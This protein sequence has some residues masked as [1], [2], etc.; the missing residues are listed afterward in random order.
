M[1]SNVSTT[2]RRVT[3]AISHFGLMAMGAFFGF[4]IVSVLEDGI[5]LSLYAAHAFLAALALMAVLLIYN[6]GY[7]REI[8]RRE[9]EEQK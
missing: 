3:E 7:L 9:K 4:I 6:R 2:R 5:D 1:V 8:F